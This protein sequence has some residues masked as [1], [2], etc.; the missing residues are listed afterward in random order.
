MTTST[1]PMKKNNVAFIVTILLALA[2]IGAWIYQLIAGMQTTG[3]GEQIVW[4]LYISA[5]FTA[6]GAGA[7][8]LALTGVSEF[9]PVFP[10]TWRA[11]NLILAV[12]SFIIGALLIAID[13]GNPIQIW[14]VIT[15]FRFSSSMVWDFWLLIVGGVVALIYLLV[16][17][18]KK[19]QKVLAILGILA[20]VAVVVT[21]SWMLSMEAAHAHPL[22][23]SGLIVIN[24]LLGAAIAGMSIAVVA[25][26]TDNRVLSWLQVALWLSLAFVFL[27][28]V[29]D[30]V[31]ESDEIGLVLIGFAAPAFW[32]QVIVGL[33]LPIV[34]LVRKTY[35]WLAGILAVFG[36]VAE[37][38]WT[39]AAGQAIPRL[40]LPQGVYFP[41]W[42]ELISVIGMIAIG[43][44]IYRLL[45]MIVKP[46]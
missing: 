31:S 45:I 5:F 34:L 11:R 16:G 1:I 18:D 29:T 4:G 13:V 7:G 20:A 25:G 39:L 42:V 40:A 10:V 15:A 3:L 14:R 37:R 38:L 30:L 27:E 21:E 28:T 17:R 41:S 19:P 46:E 12:T 8:L 44:L 23:G 35:L 26:S 24:F 2:G 22:W 36:V 43:I 33:L 32:L 6:V 9:I